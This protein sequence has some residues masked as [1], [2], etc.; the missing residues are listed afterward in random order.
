[1]TSIRT[2]PFYFA[3]GLLFGSG[4]ILS[5][6]A[7]PNKVLSFLNLSGIFT[8]RW[9]PSL[10]FVMLGA[11][12]VTLLGYRLVFRRGK[13]VL[14]DRF[15]LP[16]AKDI[17]PRILIGPAI[18]GLGWGLSGFCPGPVLTAVGTGAPQALAFCGAMLLGMILARYVLPQRS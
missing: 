5:G 16:T 3:I 6:M 4:L 1:M 18:F 9:D 14:A 10:A 15:H 11:V 8:G 2:I 13:P 7:N 17:T 12:P